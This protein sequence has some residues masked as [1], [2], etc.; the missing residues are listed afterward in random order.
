[1]KDTLDGVTDLWISNPIEGYPHGIL[2]DQQVHY[3]S[4]KNGIINNILQIKSILGNS[5]S[6]KVA[7]M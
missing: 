7:T 4:L 6:P 5:D 2:S 1:M 3:A